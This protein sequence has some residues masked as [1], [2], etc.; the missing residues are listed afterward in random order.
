MGEQIQNSHGNQ[1]A[2]EAIAL[3]VRSNLVLL[4]VYDKSTSLK[5][6]A[7]KALESAF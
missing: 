4:T 2:I 5:S 7:K 3:V 6:R 1:F